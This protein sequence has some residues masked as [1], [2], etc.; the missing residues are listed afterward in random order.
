MISIPDQE[1]N[2]SSTSQKILALAALYEGAFSVDWLQEIWGGKASQILNVL[3]LGVKKRWISQSAP[4]RFRFTD[5]KIRLDLLTTMSDSKKE[6]I[7]Q[8]AVEIMLKDLPVSE[9]EFQTATTM[10]LHVNNN[11]QGCQFLYKKGNQYRK[12]YQYERL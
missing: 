11:L 6:E 10:L 2:E 7:R 3:D 4:D 1:Q 5:S 12:I 8:Q 9:D